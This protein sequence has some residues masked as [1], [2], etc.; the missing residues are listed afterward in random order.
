MDNKISIMDKISI[1]EF[2]KK[3]D[4]FLDKDDML[5]RH[6][7]AIAFANTLAMLINYFYQ[8]ITGRLLGPA[9]YSIFGSLVA[10]TYIFSVF[11]GVIN[12][13]IAKFCSEYKD[14]YGKIKTIFLRYSVKLLLISFF[15]FAIFYLL[16]PLISRTLGIDSY[17]LI[18]MIGILIPISF[19]F[20]L[21]SGIMR[22]LQ[23]FYKYSILTILHPILKFAIGIP[24]LILGFGVFGALF[25]FVSSSI[26]ICILSF[27]F[28]TFLL[29]SESMKIESKEIIKYSFPVLIISLCINSMINLDI[30]L[31]KAIFSET[32]AGFYIASST[33][34]KVIF[35]IA[36]SIIFVMFPKISSNKEKAK[37]ILKSTLLY[38]ISFSIIVLIFVALFSDFAT[39]FTF[40]K[41][42]ANASPLLLPFGIA[43]L[44]VSLN[45]VIANYSLAIG[46]NVTFSSLSFIIFSIIQFLLIYLLHSSLLMV[47]YD[48]IIANLM[49]FILLSFK[50]EIFK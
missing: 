12:T 39:I 18:I 43:I 4:N 49:L 1:A 8:L 45:Q 50:M 9:S 30:I 10:I 36:G 37:D 5:L 23:M 7:L 24:L 17:I 41:E 11:G 6:G 40:G 22:G 20:S 14:D 29:T 2:R 19:L 33:L 48:I 3:V 34:M 47:I 16:S 21:F 25:G 26:L 15:S 13:S 44:I 46:K 32:E 27:L 38:I 28:L 35:W 42:F 31:V